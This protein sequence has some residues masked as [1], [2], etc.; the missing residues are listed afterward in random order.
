MAQE[1]S[2]SRAARI[3]DNAEAA[4]YEISV[5]GELAG[6]VTYRD[7]PDAARIALHTE[8]FPDFE[9]Q[10]LAAALA[11]FVLDDIRWRGLRVVP[12]CPYVAQYIRKHPEYADLVAH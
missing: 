1:G 10:G 6:F 4:R 2:A 3:V 11:K 12:R 5:N 8:V 9:G 7:R